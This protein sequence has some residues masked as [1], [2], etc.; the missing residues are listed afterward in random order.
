MLVFV[1]VSLFGSESGTM[2]VVGLLRLDHRPSAC[3]I[4]W[5]PPFKDCF[6]LA[7][8]LDISPRSFLSPP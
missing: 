7:V 3:W 4:C 8:L 6:L 2:L 5:F 1:L